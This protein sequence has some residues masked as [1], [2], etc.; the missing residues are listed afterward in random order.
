ML[1]RS[2]GA[3]KAA[4]DLG[5]T[6]FYEFAQ[7]DRQRMVKNT[8][9]NF[10]VTA[11]QNLLLLAEARMRGWVTTQT[12]EGYYNAGV[13][14]HMEQLSAYGASSSIPVSS[15]VDYLAANPLVEENAMEQIGEQYWVSTFLNGPEAFANF[16]RTGFPALTA[17]PYTGR[18][19]DFINRLTYPNSEIS[20]N[21]ENVGA[22]I[23]AQGPD[24]L[25]T[26]VWWHK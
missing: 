17:N 15:I 7:V 5:L 9:P 23:S 16:R 19:V 20:V 8:A 13:R 1:F 24:N 10:L 2:A 3:V 21:S 4:A 25:A 12:V 14:A 26:R 22:A 11:S 18:E 6:S